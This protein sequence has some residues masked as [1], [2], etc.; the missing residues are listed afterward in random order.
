M[1]IKI[2]LLATL[3]S[4]AFPLSGCGV[5]VESTGNSVRA[6]AKYPLECSGCEFVEDKGSRYLAGNIWNGSNKTQ[7]LCLDIEE[8]DATGN[9]V[10]SI[11][12]LSFSDRAVVKS[13]YS[14]PFG[15]GGLT[16]RASITQITFYF[17]ERGQSD[18]KATSEQ[19]LSSSYTLH[20]RTLPVPEGYVVP[21]PEP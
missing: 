7:D 20:L 11:Y 12:N 9:I 21:T 1:K 19:R 13:H 18:V 2:F 8:K 6:A 3:L 14:V 5:S 17:R 4:V 15:Q 10:S 16:R